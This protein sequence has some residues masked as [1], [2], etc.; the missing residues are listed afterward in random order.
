M[1][2]GIKTHYLKT[3]WFPIL[4]LKFVSLQVFYQ[5][6]IQINE[7]NNTFS[8]LSEKHKKKKY[9]RKKYLQNSST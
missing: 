7:I 8:F 1:D 5:K 3:V 2:R 6:Q 9:N 4:L